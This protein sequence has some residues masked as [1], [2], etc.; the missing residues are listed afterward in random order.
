MTNKGLNIET[1]R[2]FRDQAAVDPAV[3]TREKVAIAHWVQG[4]EA[5]V[6]LEDHEITIGAKDGIN[7]MEMLLI[8]FAA[9]D[10]AVVAVHASYMGLE[11]R[12]LKVAV[13]GSY[14]VA[15]YIG[16][17]GAPGPGYDGIKVQIYLDA[18]DVTPDQLAYLKQMCEQASPVGDT[19]T[20]NVPVAVDF[21]K[22][23]S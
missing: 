4:E 10:A 17:E 7:M 11:I 1:W 15:S 9:C 22:V 12:D 16:V 21:V 23:N 2:A 14:N 19:M 8:S 5:R 3:A 6:T 20:R 13:S 18:P